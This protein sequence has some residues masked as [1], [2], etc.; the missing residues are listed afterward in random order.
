M[1]AKRGL[2]KAFRLRRLNP[3]EAFTAAL[4]GKVDSV[5]QYALS[6]D[7]IKQLKERGWHQAVHSLSYENFLLMNPRQ[8]SRPLREAIASIVE[9]DSLVRD[10]GRAELQPAYGLI[11][12]VLAGS[13]K[14]PPAPIDVKKMEQSSVTIQYNET[15][16]LHAQTARW[17]KEKLAARGVDV[18]I[19][20]LAFDMYYEV[21]LGKKGGMIIAGKGLDYPDGLANLAYFR[22]DVP[23]NFLF[24]EN[25]VLD[26]ELRGLPFKNVED[27][28]QAYQDL[29]WKIL[30]QKTIVPLFFG[31]VTSGLWSP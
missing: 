19:E 14:S 13:L 4:L 16:D 28:V 12:P 30:A 20:P 3:G 25:S 5:E 6:E 1:R 18:L 2:H 7:Q 17:L 10:L 23:N 9:S 21:L 26:E 8:V 31:H 27:R 11:P 22:T 29:Q 15:N 24:M